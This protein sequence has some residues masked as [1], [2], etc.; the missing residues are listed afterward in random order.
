M[1]KPSTARA[2]PAPEAD[3]D[4]G[5][6][7]AIVIPTFNERENIR[8]LLD[9]LRDALPETA[10][11]VVIVDDDSPDGTADLVRQ[12]ANEQD[13]VRCIQRIGRRGLSSACI[14]GVLATASPFVAIMDA[15]LQHDETK[16]TTMLAKLEQ[17][18]LDV[19]VGSRFVSGGG[20]GTF[21][22][23]RLRLS[24]IGK[25]LSRLVTRAE[26]T[27]PMSGFFV[28]RRT[29]FDTVAHRLSGKGF[30]ILT[31]LF[32][33]AQEPI[34]FAEIPYTFGTRVAGQSKLDSLVMVDYVGLLVDKLFGG[35]VPTRFLLFVAVGLLGVLI[36]LSVLGLMYRVLGM[37]FYASQVIAT[38][39]AM[40]INFQLN[41]VVTYR[42][43][44][45]R[46][47]ALARGFAL[48]VL[49]CAI[50]AV[51]NFQ[52]AE[53]LYEYGVFWAMAGFLGAVVGSVW[54]Y[55]VNTTLTW[56]AAKR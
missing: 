39:T 19:V 16:L 37:G 13:N 27:D 26:L 30:K 35:L 24:R 48:F 54:N 53:M 40:V 12:I 17:E 47:A 3:I 51:A 11:E 14:E 25:S 20:V 45:L 29:F 2:H 44:R 8:P 9:R 15:D 4:R 28:M 18:S 23:G 55:G 7:L 10:Y 22:P 50:G 36:H 31:D 46:G 1:I 21:S 52:V 42:D 5:T 49:I 34:R 6:E 56:R 32:A 43:R 41:N 38:F 33:S